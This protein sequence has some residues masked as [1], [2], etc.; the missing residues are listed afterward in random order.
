MARK[1]FVT[2][3]SVND[4]INMD[5]DTFNKLSVSELRQVVSRLASAGNKRLK[6]FEKSGED[7]PSVR[8]IKRS[9]GKFSTRGKDLNALRSEYSR[10]RNFFQSSTSTLKGWKNVKKQTISKLEKY[11]INVTSSQFDTLWRAYEELKEVSPEVSTR[12]LKY[13]TL[14]EISNIMDDDVKD[15][16]TI[17]S[18]MQES[19]D[20][21][22]EEQAVADYGSSGVS[23]FFEI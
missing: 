7:S 15:V 17:I 10:A 13:R 8:Y 19:L 6:N 16:D 4:L 14:Q 3:R 20:E 11:G 22:Y 1:S 12:S 21:I 9:G 5:I 23:Q 18:R 2:G